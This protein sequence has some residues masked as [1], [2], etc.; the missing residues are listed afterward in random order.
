M[1]DAY[2]TARCTTGAIFGVVSDGDWAADV[3]E[4]AQDVRA[5]TAVTKRFH[6]IMQRLV[7]GMRKQ[8]PEESSIAA[9]LLDIQDP[10]TGARILKHLN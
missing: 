6:C 5:G 3:W 10:E 4:Y 1:P 2:H 8:R 9:H 7:D